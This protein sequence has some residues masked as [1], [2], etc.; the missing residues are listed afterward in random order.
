MGYFRV[1]VLYYICVISNITKLISQKSGNLHTYSSIARGRSRTP[2]IFKMEIFVTIFYKD[3]HFR[4]CR[5][6]I[7][8]S[9]SQFNYY[10][11]SL[12]RIQ[13][14][15]SLNFF[16][17]SKENKDVAQSEGESKISNLPEEKCYRYRHR[18]LVENFALK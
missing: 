17:H 15:S 18:E 2:A 16:M 7:L 13:S 6:P 9:Y 10:A 14:M 8:T 11:Y 1:Y 12:L 3:V 5:S 4:C